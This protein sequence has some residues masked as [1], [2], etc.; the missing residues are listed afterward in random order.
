MIQKLNDIIKTLGWKD[1]VIIVLI[2]Y[3][4]YRL[5]VIE[6]MSETT[7]DSIRSAI[8]EVYKVDVQA[9]KH[10]GDLAQE[11]YNHDTGELV[12]DHDVKIKGKLTTTGDAFIKDG[13]IKLTNTTEGAGKINLR[14]IDKSQDCTIRGDHDPDGNN[15][16][17]PEVLYVKQK[18]N[19]DAMEFSGNNIISKN[20]LHLRAQDNI[21][22]LTSKQTIVGGSPSSTGDLLVKRNLTTDGN[23]RLNGILDMGNNI[24]LNWNA[25]RFK[26]EGDEVHQISVGEEDGIQLKTHGPFKVYSAQGKG[27]SVNGK[28]EGTDIK[29]NGAFKGRYYDILHVGKQNDKA[30][31]TSPLEQDRNLVRL[32]FA[33]RLDGGTG[34]PDNDNIYYLGNYNNGSTTYKVSG[35][36]DGY[37]S[38]KDSDKGRADDPK[39]K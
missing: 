1:I 27:V 11:I 10:L 2:F 20:R 33:K 4:V 35:V 29:S 14:N 36:I 6:K 31:T 7:D 13:A 38:S 18:L 39:P 32:Q 21:Y 12:L 34:N 25:L 23:T 24:A 28:I 5:N 3:V 26:T 22:L 37:S 30:F 9:I 8:K 16:V 15:V 17:I 19:V